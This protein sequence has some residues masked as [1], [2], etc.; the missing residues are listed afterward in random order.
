MSLFNT[1][2]GFPMDT[3]RGNTRAYPDPF[4]TYATMMTPRTIKDILRWCEHLWNR[5]GTYA[6]ASRRVI[7]Y[8]LTKIEIQDANDQEK[9]KYLDFLNNTLGV[10][11][12][13]ALLGDDFMCYGNSF[14]S[15]YVPFRRYLSCKHCGLERPIKRVKY[16]FENFRFAFTCPACGQ[17]NACEKPR[18]K[19]TAE[20]DGI[21]VIRW[22]PHQIEV[23][24]HP[25]SKK[26]K[27]FWDPPADLA[28][29]I[30]KGD[31]FFLESMPW[32]MIETIKEKKLFEFSD[33]VIYH[34]REDTIAGMKCAGWGVSRFMTNFSQAFYV[35]MLKMYNEVLCQEYIVPFRVI[36][37]AAGNSK[38]ADPMVHSN[39]GSFNNKVLGM[40]NQHR[41]KPGGYYAVPFPI[42]YQ[43]LGGEAE[44]LVTQELINQ[45]LDEMLNAAGVPAELYKGTITMQAMPA[46][47]RLFQQTWPHLVAAY[48]GWIRWLVDGISKALNWEPVL[49]QM[50]PVTLADDVEN[51]QILLQL[52]AGNKVSM[53]KALAPLGIDPDEDIRTIFEENAQFQ[54]MQEAYQQK[55]QNRQQMTQNMQSS[56]MQSAGAPQGGPQQSADPSVAAQGNNQTPDQMMAQ[57][58][59]M[60]NQLLNM[61][62]E[63]RT[64][65]MRK[66]KHSNETLWALVKAKI[67]SIKTQAQSQ[68]G[69]QA[70]Q[71]MTQPQ[72]GQGPQQA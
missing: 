34:M 45:A 29:A 52:A 44:K 53:H 31:P 18:D 58:E 43:V 6:M 57:A 10:M 33:G 54:E 60:A 50:Q 19:R 68:G 30:S 28:N 27:Y 14:S 22:S 32:E 21:R 56:V 20:E 24:E 7:R 66:I 9:K 72:Q 12:E 71:Q 67:S 15:L 62:Y 25:I 36:S 49:A 40:L 39:V 61:P 13:L 69:Y 59:Q 46:A 1:P 23:Q 2:P 17:P 63:Q 70:L 5:N 26:R 35:Q 16:T 47:L 3:G 42:E 65:E 48:N 11:T 64:S 55:M 37:P 4:L 51:K 38:E 8:F 41:R